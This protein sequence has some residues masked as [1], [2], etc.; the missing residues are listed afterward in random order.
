MMPTAL[1]CVCV[2]SHFLLV[3]ILLTSWP[4]LF[5]VHIFTPATYSLRVLLQEDGNYRSRRSNTENSFQSIKTKEQKYQH[6]C[7][8]CSGY[9]APVSDSGNFHT[10]TKIK[11]LK[12]TD[13]KLKVAKCHCCC[14]KIK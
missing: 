7:I 1:I 13:S 2:N 4:I 9:S 14:L 3:L 6:V 12:M 10:Q 8:M 5:L 11:P